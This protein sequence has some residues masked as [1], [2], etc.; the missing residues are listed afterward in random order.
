MAREAAAGLTSYPDLQAR[1]LG[2]AIESL[3]ARGETAEA[4]RLGRELARRFAGK[5]GDLSTREI[6]GQLTRAMASEPVE[7]QMRLYRSLMR[8]FGR[9]AGAAMWD[10]VAR[11]FVGA[12]ATAGRWRD[13]RAALA[14]AR[15]TL[16]GGFG[17]QIDTEMRALDAELAQ[18]ER[19]AGGAAR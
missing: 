10:E 2:V 7:E 19:A 12:L 16:G 14:L 8:Q 15:E 5:R 18:K 3:R 9:G 13:A 6:A 11:P 1:F 4:D 17:S